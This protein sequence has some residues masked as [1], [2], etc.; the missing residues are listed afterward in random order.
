VVAIGDLNGAADALEAI[1]RG[2]RLVDGSGRWT[3][4]R[5]HLVQVG[6]LFNRG[7]RGRAAFG[8]LRALGRQARAAGGDVTVLLGNHE[9]MTALGNESYCTV[10]EY[11]S[12]APARE[13]ALWKERVARQMVRL[14]RDHPPRGPIA[15]L[16]PRL[17]AWSALN[18]P[19]RRE[20]R[21]ELGPRGA[22]GRALRAL[23]VAIRIADTAFVHSVPSPRW[24]R[25]GIDGLNQAARATWAARPRF[26]RDLP[27]SSLFRAVDGPLW[28]RELVGRETRA[29]RAALARSLDGLGVRRIVIG[30]TQTRHLPDGE[31]GRIAL[32]HDGRVICIDV[33]LGLGPNPPLAALDLRGD[34][35]HEWTPSGRRRLA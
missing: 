7:P 30:H 35:L 19:G 6:D 1:L 9:A 2:T 16:E 28:N 31:R 5:A 34:A 25:R 8:R 21:R 24:A 22:T 17:A 10:E 29:T 15:P 12:F 11:L 26:W 3:G 13:R 33:S 27:R 23:P 4:G 18:A 14:L 20:L 32:R